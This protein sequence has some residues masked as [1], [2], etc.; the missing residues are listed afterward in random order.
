MEYLKDINYE[1]RVHTYVFEIIV[2][3]VVMKGVFSTIPSMPVNEMELK[4]EAVRKLNDG[5]IFKTRN[6]DGFIGFTEEDITILEDII[7]DPRKTCARGTHVQILRPRVNASGEGY[8]RGLLQRSTG[9]STTKD[10]KRAAKEL[11]HQEKVDEYKMKKK[12]E[13]DAIA[14]GTPLPA[15]KDKPSKVAIDILL[16]KVV[17]YF[18]EPRKMTEAAKT[19]GM[20]YQKVRYCLMLVKDKGFKDAKYDL[21]ETTID[22]SKAFQLVKKG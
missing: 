8:L 15:K 17:E 21:V 1:S 12:E 13:Q 10:E 6:E 2:G 20:Q 11:K 16:D 5:C 14:A 18:S 3:D 7:F 4:E 19:L 9:G 22:E